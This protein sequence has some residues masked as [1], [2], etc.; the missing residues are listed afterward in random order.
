[1]TTDVD[2]MR[3]DQVHAQEVGILS[4]D[5]VSTSMLSAG[6]VGYLIMGIKSTRVRQSMLS[7]RITLGTGCAGG[8]HAAP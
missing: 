4:P 8:R 5:L 3:V 1:M 2:P 6:Q 7:A